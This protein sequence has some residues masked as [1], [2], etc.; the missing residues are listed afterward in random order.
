MAR[1]EEAKEKLVRHQI[2]QAGRTDNEG[3]RLLEYLGIKSKDHP[4]SWFVNRK[5]QKQQIETTKI[6]QERDYGCLQ[7]WQQM[8]RGNCGYIYSY[9]TF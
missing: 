4:C 3:S 8:K 1:V 6:L 9:G 5:Q 7:R 2:R